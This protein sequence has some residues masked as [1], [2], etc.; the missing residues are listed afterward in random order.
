MATKGLT[1]NEVNVAFIQEGG[2]IEVTL[3][4]F[5]KLVLL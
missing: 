4:L 5:T 2:C 1:K 3:E